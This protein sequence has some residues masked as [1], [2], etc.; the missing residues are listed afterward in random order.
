[1]TPWRDRGCTV[2]RVNRFGAIVQRYGF[3]VLIIVAAIESALEVVFR[4]DAELA[5]R[6][7]P[8]FAAPA[9]ALA[10]LPLLARRRYPFGAP[11]VVFAL[12]A[13][14][15]LVD[16]RL[17]VFPAGVFVAAMAAAL[18]LGS[19]QDDSRA[20]LGLAIAL[21][22]VTIV[23]SNDPHHTASEFIFI[24]VLLVVGWL[25]GRAL[26]ERGERAD[27]AE[28][29]AARAERERA[30]AARVAI[31]EERARIAREMHDVVAHAVSVMVLQVGAVRHRLPASLARE[32]AALRDVEE[33]GRTALAEMRQLLGA[34]RE[35]GEPAEMTPQPGLGSLDALLAQVRRAGLP[36][37]LHVEGEARPLPPAVDLSA[38]RIVQE[39][40]T[41]VLKHAHASRADV[42][43]RYD[44]RDLRIEVRDDGRGSGAG[45]GLG[46]GLVGIGERVKLYGGELAAGRVDGGGF[47]LR[48]RL[49][50]GGYRS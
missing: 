33:T 46:H 39:G 44:A 22:S 17:V 19:L 3:D 48:T 18:L 43:V 21:A 24:P 5:P 41:N 11:V 14:L 26:R 6:T 10:L 38:Y 31:A 16:G 42:A 45:D 1:M 36:V 27:A 12:C 7:S 28:E 29:R 47:A 50:I 49:P 37:A 13:A 15:S 9:I 35:N 34:M 40:L 23:V 25:A 4:H 2:G 32:T 30:A 20:R 8:W